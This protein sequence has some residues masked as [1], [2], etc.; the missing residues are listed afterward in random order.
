M[1]ITSRTSAREYARN[2]IIEI[3]KQQLHVDI[4]SKVNGAQAENLYQIAKRN[5]YEGTEKDFIN[6]LLAGGSGAYN[7]NI[8]HPITGGNYTLATAVQVVSS[9]PDIPEVAKSGLTITF[10]DGEEWRTYR[11]KYMYDPSHPENF[12]NTD[13]WYDVY[14]SEIIVISEGAYE[15]L[16]EK[17]PNKFYF[18]YEDDT[19]YTPAHIEDEV[20]TTDE[21]I[22]N[23]VLE[24]SGSIID[25]VLYL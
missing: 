20:L 7:L 5:G 10:Y 18:T 19:P 25:G 8:N 9:D 23:G 12:A 13:N 14:E 24:T 11:Y 6:E 21:H 2:A 22:E 15:R 1:E 17:D 3:K 16:R 4:L